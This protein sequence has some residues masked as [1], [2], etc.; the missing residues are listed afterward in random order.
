[1][2]QER[3]GPLL[4][5]EEVAQRL[6]LHVESV[7]RYIRSKELKAVKFGNRGGYRITEEDLQ[8]FI[9]K[10]KEEGAPALAPTH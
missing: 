4:T 9:A 2:A 8:A 1:M 6:N 7:R 10:K 3:S 5:V